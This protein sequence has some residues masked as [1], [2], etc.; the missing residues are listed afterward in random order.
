MTFGDTFA[1]SAGVKV[2]V[3]PTRFD[4][5]SMQSW[6]SCSQLANTRNLRWKPVQCRWSR[7]VGRTN[8]EDSGI[9]REVELGSSLDVPVSKSLLND[10][11][12]EITCPFKQPL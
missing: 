8:R 3:A 5:E 2:K 11:S 9:R 4:A 6:D 12:N 10:Y 1:G 7:E